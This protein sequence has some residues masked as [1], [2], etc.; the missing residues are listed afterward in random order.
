M[1]LAAHMLQYQTKIQNLVYILTLRTE[2]RQTLI[3]P[4]SALKECIEAP[5]SL[6]SGIKPTNRGSELSQP[7]I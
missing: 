4:F 3:Y 6:K 1:Q 2:F 5:N 7:V